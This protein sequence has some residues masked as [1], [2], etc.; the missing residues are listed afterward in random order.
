[1]FWKTVK[2]VFTDKGTLPEKLLCILQNM[3]LLRCTQKLCIHTEHEW[4]CIYLKK[5]DSHPRTSSVFYRTCW[6]WNSVFYRTWSPILFLYSTEHESSLHFY[7][8]LAE[9]APLSKNDDVTNKNYRPISMLCI[10]QNMKTLYSTEH[11]IPGY[12][13]Y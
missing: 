4:L 3:F 13:L 6:R 11:E 8:L 9:I 10:L 7:K 2:P 1:M 12:P 5:F